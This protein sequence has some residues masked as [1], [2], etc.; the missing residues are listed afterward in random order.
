M[1]PIQDIQVGDTIYYRLKEEDAPTHPDKEWPGR[2]IQVMSL[3]VT[4]EMLEPGYEG[5]TEMV[6]CEQIV[7]VKRTL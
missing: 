5:D 1:I 3:S 2:V 7:R 4:V 6:Y